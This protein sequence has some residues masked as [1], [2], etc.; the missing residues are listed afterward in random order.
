MDIDGTGGFGC[1][2][3]KNGAS[4]CGGQWEREADD[5]PFV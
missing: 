4:E 1:M 5:V 3:I 2:T